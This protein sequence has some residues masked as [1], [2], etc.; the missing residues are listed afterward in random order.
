MCEW[1]R[2]YEQALTK[3]TTFELYLFQNKNQKRVCH[4][5]HGNGPVKV[6]DLEVPLIS[7]GSTVSF[8]AL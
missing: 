1:S 4:N 2:L 8:E 7:A 6:K 3:Y 5:I